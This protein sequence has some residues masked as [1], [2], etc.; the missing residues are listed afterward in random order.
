MTKL[1]R[2]K[3]IYACLKRLGIAYVDIT[4]DGSSD[5]G[6]V[7]SVTA[8]DGNNA[9]V[10]LPKNKTVTVSFQRNAY[11]PAV[12]HYRMQSLTQKL[13]LNDA[14]TDWAYDLLEAHY[15]GWELDEGSSGKIT[16]EVSK[17]QGHIVHDARIVS[18][19]TTKVE[20]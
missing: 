16:F 11:D 14:L 4:Y 20:V 1:D 8:R 7:E 5:S 10:A 18:T 17:R 3:V 6:C 2:P 13:N 19:M 15:A 9:V 12:K